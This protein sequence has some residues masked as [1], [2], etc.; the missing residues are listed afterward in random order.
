MTPGDRVTQLYPQTLGTHFS[1]LLRHTW[2]TVVLFFNPGH[3]T[4]L[5]YLLIIISLQK[6]YFTLRFYV[7]ETLYTF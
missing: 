6:C 1:R 3:H 7:C 4:E 2:V 5:L